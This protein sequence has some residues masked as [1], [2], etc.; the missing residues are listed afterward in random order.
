[1]LKKLTTAIL[2]ASAS[3]A[4]VCAAGADD[5]RIVVA[6]D[7]ITAEVTAA[8]ELQDG[9]F[10][11]TGVRLP[12]Q[13]EATASPS[14]RVG[15]SA[16]N[17]AL[18]GIDFS[19]LK[20]DEIIIK[21]VGKDLIVTGDRPRGT[22]YAVF[23]L[24]EQEYGIRFWTASVSYYP[25][26]PGA[27]KMPQ[28]DLRYAPPFAYREAF[29]GLRGKFAAQMRNN[30]HFEEIPEAWGGNL[31]ILGWSHTFRKLMSSEEYFKSHPEWFAERNGRR[32]PDGQPCLSNP[33]MRRKLIHNTMAWLQKNPGT[34]L[35]ALC[36]N[37]NEH[38]CQCASCNEFVRR[39]GNQSDLLLD[40]IN[41]V[42][43]AMEK[44][45]FSCKI[46]TLAYTY[47]RMPPVT[48]RPKSNV[49]IQL[50][51]IECDFSKAAE[52]EA[53][54]EFA[55]NINAWKRI[56]PELHIWNYTTNFRKYYLPHPNWS[57]L[58]PDLRFFAA[59][60]VHGVFEQGSSAGTG[61]IADLDQLRAWL[62]SKLLW[63]PRQ[64]SDKLINEF[65]QGYYGQASPFIRKYIDLM[66]QAAAA[67]KVKL[68]CY[69]ENTPWLDTASLIAAWKAM[70]EARKIVGANPDLSERVAVAAVPINMALLINPDAVKQ[71]QNKGIK[72]DVKTLLDRQ[73][74]II[75]KAGTKHLEEDTNGTFGR[76]AS[77]ILGLHGLL[78]R[79][80][81]EPAQARG[82]DWYG[83]RT[84]K[85]FRLFGLGTQCFIEND[86][87]GAH[88]QSVRI[89]VTK[90]PQWNVQYHQLPDFGVPYE[91]YAS[92]RCDGRE[93][94]GNAVKMGVYNPE[95]KRS[96]TIT[97]PAEKIA[98]S[99]YNLVKITDLP[100]VNGCYVFITPIVNST[101]DNI[102]IDRFVIIKK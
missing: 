75:R 68:S 87:N 14:I 78:P 96:D 42:A 51:N 83:V 27:F 70:E 52:S 56:A 100:V 92:L 7:A 37:D 43:S 5:C 13:G 79:D 17:A 48:I 38:Y 66:T 74:A 20:N 98:G 59:N 49:I 80:G 50:S 61:G 9:I 69:M 1:M 93:P 88:S 25:S 57:C 86:A 36:Q 8:K 24:L 16:E 18:L 63:D 32:I 85:D 97:V 73:F 90:S 60:N 29:Y 10:K 72:L 81:S 65:L 101:V 3:A 54:A 82:R 99:S 28:L 33:E 77:I 58:A 12:I 45:Y 41:D 102:W 26:R 35:L 34:R 30:G 15:Q 89:P 19:S 84:T 46:V 95:T 53:N 21:N 31:R 6:P 22:L 91:L 62:V 94:Q 44:E 11:V 76:H 71:I 55:K 2:I 64:D 40:V 67:G 47:T 39:N 4:T 23:E